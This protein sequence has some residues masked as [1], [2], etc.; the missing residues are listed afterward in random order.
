MTDVVEVLDGIHRLGLDTA[1]LVYLNERHPRYGAASLLLGSRH[2]TLLGIDVRAAE[3]AADLRARYNLRT[4]DACQVA[5]ALA[6]GCSGYLTP[7]A[8]LRRLTEL[9][10]N[11]LDDLRP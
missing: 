4:P 3:R 6:A 7:D 10:I 8:G 11:V 5:V 2:F 9:R 1:P